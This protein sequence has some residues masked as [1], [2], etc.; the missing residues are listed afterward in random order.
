VDGDF[1][2]YFAQKPLEMPA[3]EAVKDFQTFYSDFYDVQIRM[4]ISEK[5]QFL[6]LHKERKK[7]TVGVGKVTTSPSSTLASKPTC[8]NNTKKEPEIQKKTCPDGKGTRVLSD[9]LEDS[10]N[11][12]CLDSKA[13]SCS[14]TC[15]YRFFFL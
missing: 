12:D 8:K 1:E 3:L 10:D 13:K 9:V 5:H 15:S 11:D 6:K 14:E 2:D 4:T 7:Q